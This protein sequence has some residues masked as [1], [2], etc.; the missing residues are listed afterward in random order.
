MQK[1]V[2]N[3][4]FSKILLY[5]I[6]PWTII[7]LSFIGIYQFMLVKYEN[8][9]IMRYE[10]TNKALAS[11]LDLIFSGAAHTGYVLI[12]SPSF[13]EIERENPG[14]DIFNSSMGELIELRALFS[15]TATI[16]DIIESLFLFFPNAGRVLH[17]MGTESEEL[18]FSSTNRMEGYPAEFWR[19]I[20]PV[21]YSYRVLNPTI[22][23][24][25]TPQEIRLIPIIIP[26]QS[27]GYYITMLIREDFIMQVLKN[28]H[29]TANTIVSI[30]SVDGE[31]LISTGTADDKEQRWQYQETDLFLGDQMFTLTTAFP[32][33]DIV[34]LTYDIRL[35]M[36]ISTLLL[37]LLSSVISF[38][39]S[40]NI[41]K[42]VEGLIELMRRKASQ[43]SGGS[44]GIQFLQKGVEN[45]LLSSE[46][47][48]RNLTDI[49]PIAIENYM[50]RLILD[51][52]TANPWLTMKK[53][54]T[55]GFDFPYSQFQVIL[56]HLDPSEQLFTKLTQDDISLF[57]QG[58]MDLISH[59][60]PDTL[61]LWQIGF[62]EH[63]IR[64]LL[65]IPPGTDS[66]SIIP[67]LES[68]ISIFSTDAHL[69]NITIGVGTIYSE[70]EYI[71]TSYTEAHTA[72]SQASI[73][74]PNSV[75]LYTNEKLQKAYI[76]PEQD[77]NKFTDDLLLG[78][79][80][81]VFLQ[82]DEILQAN[83]NKGISDEALMKLFFRIYL[84]IQQV[85]QIK[86]LN[87]EQLMGSRYIQIP[88]QYNN[89]SS[90]AF[91]SY[92]KSLITAA[93]KV[94][95]P[96]SSHK[97]E[98]SDIEEFLEEN[99][100]RDIS[101]DDLA[102]RYKTTPVYVSKCI[103]KLFGVPLTSYLAEKRIS[104]ASYLLTETNNLSIEEI[105]AICGYNNRIHF[106][107]SFKQRR[108]VPPTEY[109]KQLNLK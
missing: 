69:K 97:I 78:K 65:N 33:A 42:P 57:Y 94:I 11:E 38:L 19:S 20:T 102:D 24:K 10:Q 61:R 8:E 89:L 41:S 39:L 2:K 105:A 28:H 103:K 107:R 34:E 48:N 79:S 30:N 80:A 76:L 84:I 63:T 96:I 9:I 5:S 66:N 81:Q 45:L 47:L 32:R 35:I 7:L 108:G 13:N 56:V 36:I 21:N 74:Q 62:E 3:N 17:S 12:N 106:T 37:A 64:I 88:L 25:E 4:Y 98:K 92:L 60:F 1:R 85:L 31:T 86:K 6:I 100:S 104:F 16:N 99:F 40:R 82:L 73:D 67:N 27:S 53:L 26:K 43:D 55:Y 44:G 59:S 46:T 22:K 93:A 101:L 23:K 75:L 52:K 90:S 51:R 71:H 70:V 77:V 50:E 14:Q 68:F 49:T 91:L 15:D 29:I 72:L 54:K 83:T 109:R 58:A 87:E 95:L 18:F